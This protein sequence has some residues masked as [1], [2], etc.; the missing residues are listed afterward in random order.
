LIWGK[1]EIKDGA[2]VLNPV[3]DKINTMLDKFTKATDLPNALPPPRRGGELEAPPKRLESPQPP[4]LD[5]D[6]PF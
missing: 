2:E 3:L 1:K 6:I 5:D 4:S